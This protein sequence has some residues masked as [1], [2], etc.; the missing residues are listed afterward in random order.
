MPFDR[1]R[2]MLFDQS[3]ED[4][5]AARPGYPKRLIDEMIDQSGVPNGGRI[6]EIGCGTGQLTIPLAVHGY[7]IT[8]V[9]LGEALARRAAENLTPFP[10]AEVIHAN[11]ESWEIEAGAYDLIVSAQAFHW[12]DPE[13]GY[14]KVHAALRPSGRLALIWN[15]FPGCDLPVHRALDKV[16]RSCAPQLVRDSGNSSLEQ[17]LDRTLQELRASGS[18]DEPNVV[19]VPWTSTY[20]TAR[21][22]QLLRTHS[23]HLA[24]DA[25]TFD[26]LLAAVASTIDRFGGMIER[27]QVATLVLARPQ[28][29]SAV[30]ED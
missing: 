7:T 16:Y 2:R 11:F 30:N 17:R 22:L 6:L 1:N 24:L 26:R 5:D 14:P 8:A 13:I 18:F 15:L 9:E 12:I 21:Y 4:Y 28:W 20:T 23:D 25:P 27:P 29:K 3:A 19:W 10:N